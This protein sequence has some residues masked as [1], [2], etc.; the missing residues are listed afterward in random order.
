MLQADLEAFL[1]PEQ[2]DDELDHNH[3]PGTQPPAA[4][5]DEDRQ[6]WS[7]DPRTDAAARTVASRVA[8]DLAVLTNEP[9]LGLFRVQQHIHR[10]VPMVVARKEDMLQ[11]STRIAGMLY[12][13]E[14]AQKTVS[15]MATITNFST[16]QQHLQTSIRYKEQLN[17]M[18]KEAKDKG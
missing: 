9:S 17:A 3:P 6:V 7:A 8:G 12:D 14:Y 10:A 13:V 16:I 11:L 5:L 2:D 15:K 4:G 1:Q 18:A